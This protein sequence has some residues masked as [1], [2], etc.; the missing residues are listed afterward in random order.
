MQA[1]Q[2]DDDDPPDDG[3]GD[4]ELADRLAASRPELDAMLHA[5]WRAN[6]AGALF[7]TRPAVRVGRY[8]LLREVATGGGGS[9]FVARDPEL[10]RDIA[11]KLI[12]APDP[13]L[14]A[15]ALAEGQTVARLSHPNVVPVFDVGVVDDRVYLAMELVRGESLR[16]FAHHA[17]LRELVRAYRQAG[18]GLVAAHA[19]GLVHRD[20]KPDNAMIG[21]DGRVRVV[22]FGLAGAEGATGI[23][24]TPRYMAPEQRA[25]DAATPAVDQYA[26][27]VSLGEGARARG[28][29]VPGWLEAIV[30][31]GSNHVPGA[32]F[33]TMAALLRALA[34]DPRTRW[35]RRLLIATP[36][37]LAAA[38]FAIGRG[39][40]AGEVT[41]CDTGAAAIAPAWTAERAAAAHAHVVALGTPFAIG[42]APRTR[43]ALADYARRWSASHDAACVAARTEPSALVV[44]RRAACLASARNQL[45]ATLDVITAIDADALPD[46]MRA[47]SELP[48]LARCTDAATLVNDIPP[49]PPDQVARVAE[50]TAELDR[51]RVRIDAARPDAATDAAAAVDHARA[52]GYRPLLAVALLAHGRAEFALNQFDA[53]VAPLTEAVDLAIPVRDDATAVEAYA[54]AILARTASTAPDL[55]LAGT[56]PMIAMATRLGPRD[57]FARALLHNHIGVIESSAGRPDKARAELTTALSLAREING[58]GAVELAWVRSNL[59]LV[60]A[61]PGERD[62]LLAEAVAIARDRLGPDHPQTLDHEFAAGFAIADP[63][64]ARAALRSPVTRY[65]RVHPGHQSTIVDYAYEL[66]ILDFAEGDLAAARTIFG[67]VLDASGGEDVAKVRVEIARSYVALIDRDGGASASF[68][69]LAADTLPTPDTPWHMLTLPADVEV[70]LSVISRDAGDRRGAHA[71]L[72][73]AIAYLER[74]EKVNPIAAI[75]RRLA[76]VRGLRS[77]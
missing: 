19:A 22:D 9:V 24:G 28:K 46:A 37:V 31:R 64:R 10:D 15:R 74:A 73:R 17:T 58:P 50:I 43:E 44:D 33:P 11:I 40:D 67:L 21:S 25:G 14:R 39:G 38:G 62:K 63:A 27:A 42:S 26:F 72:D 41:P 30:R 71:S 56:A 55:V 18:D 2:D 77:K 4:P 3:R 20:F 69:R 7:G 47:L 65:A 59:A 5:V 53:S 52:L 16:A 36:I 12:A 34:N 70:A 49:P 51:A 68:G 45:G 76:W 23:G 32:R 75:T 57:R 35:K 60:T 8:E 1:G 48:D 66:A 61:A 54:R 13:A 29:P 6:A